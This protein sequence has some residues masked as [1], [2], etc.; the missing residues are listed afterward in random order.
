MLL[1]LIPIALLLA[2]ALVFIAGL[3]GLHQY[4]KSREEGRFIK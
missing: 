3:Y 2:A 4:D 1:L